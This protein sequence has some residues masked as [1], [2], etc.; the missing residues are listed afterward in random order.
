MQLGLSS[1]AM[2]VD[3]ALKSRQTDGIAT[4]IDATTQTRHTLDQKYMANCFKDDLTTNATTDA[5]MKK[6]E[7]TG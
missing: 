1:A 2:K 4:T 3:A 7:L 5:T 6:I